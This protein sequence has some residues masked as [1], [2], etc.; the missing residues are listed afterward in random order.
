M[1]SED[2]LYSDDIQC[3]GMQELELDE[4]NSYIDDEISNGEDLLLNMGHIN[5]TVVAKPSTGTDIVCTDVKISVENPTS[6]SLNISSNSPLRPGIF[7]LI[8]LHPHS[9][10]CYHF[11]TVITPDNLTLKLIS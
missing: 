11:F 8:T 7:A 10:V 3:S 9:S 4:M 2:V 1:K 5:Q 6:Q